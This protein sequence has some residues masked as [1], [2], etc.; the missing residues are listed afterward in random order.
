MAASIATLSAPV[1]ASTFENKIDNIYKT[2]YT[3]LNEL[4]LID[5]FLSI[6]N[7][8]DSYYDDAT[9]YLGDSKNNTLSAV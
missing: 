1:L 7:N 6:W 8:A 2:N 3:A 9:A 5:D 4:F